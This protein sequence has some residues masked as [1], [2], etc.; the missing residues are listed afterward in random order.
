[1]HELV[2]IR[3]SLIAGAAILCAGHAR[4]EVA[5][6]D[7]D[8]W[9]VST[10]GRVN[11]FYSY[12]TGDYQ[13]TGGTPGKGGIIST[14]FQ[15]APDDAAKTRFTTSRVHTGFV[16]SILGLTV[17][18]QISADLKV[19]GHMAIWWP[20]ETDQYRGYSSMVPDPRES[21]VKIEGPWGG[22]QAGR[23]LGLHDRGGTMTDFLYANG[24][25]IGGPCNAILQGPLCGNIGYGYQ[26]PGFTAGIDY[27]TPVVAGFQLTAGIYDPVK[28]G[29]GGNELTRTPVPRVEAE[30]NYT[31]ETSTAKL[32]LYVNGM[33]QKAGND[34]A[35][36]PIVVN[37]YG[38]AY[39]G[40]L[41]LGSFKLG[42]GGNRDKGTGDFIALVG[43]VPL[44]NAG[45]LRTGDGY[46]GQAMYTVGDVDICA[47]AGVTRALETVDDV[48]SE[49][50]LIKTRL[51]M[52]LGINYHLGPVVMNT[53]VFRAQHE[54]W[55]GEHQNMTFVHA[56]MTFVW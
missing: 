10:D 29:Y 25:S 16:G 32:A 1:L 8:G 42:A 53:Q 3:T 13:P 14:P 30:A 37:A 24:Y 23:A 40:R 39:G 5:L 28:I 34:V 48:L 55:R 27:N 17:K 31:F 47:G 11:G 45:V 51:G 18:K 19:T 44:D 35:G 4:A 12:E 2:K 9:S 50:S 7:K 36:V 22:L 26:F 33:W 20:I 6:V 21:Y 38:V 52:N 43:P 56:G 49:N 15:A 54:Y 41:E 46:F